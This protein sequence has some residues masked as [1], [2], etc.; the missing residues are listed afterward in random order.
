MKLKDLNPSPILPY[1]LANIRFLPIS[2]PPQLTYHC[3]TTLYTSFP[4]TMGGNALL[5]VVQGIHDGFTGFFFVLFS[6]VGCSCSSLT[7]WFARLLLSSVVILICILLF[8]NFKPLFFFLFG[9]QVQTL[10]NFLCG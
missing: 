8:S 1:S 4:L 10:F 9:L 7:L 2:F 6:F 5:L 3:T